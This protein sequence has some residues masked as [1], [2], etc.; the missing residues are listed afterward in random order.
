MLHRVKGTRACSRPR[1][2]HYNVQAPASAAVRQEEYGKYGIIRE[3]DMYAK[4]AEFM[5]WATEVKRVD[6]EVLPKFEEK[7]LFK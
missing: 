7:E 3:T 1:V 4:R 5:L 2:V 6:L